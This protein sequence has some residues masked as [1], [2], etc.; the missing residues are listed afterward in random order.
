[1]NPNGPGAIFLVARYS[2]INLD[3]KNAP[4]P[5]IFV[6]FMQQYQTFL[7]KND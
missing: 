6:V 2:P 3:E 7:L 4:R 5:G 1:M